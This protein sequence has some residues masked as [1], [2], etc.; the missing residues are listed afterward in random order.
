MP[1]RTSER[2]TRRAIEGLDAGR[3]IRDHE[4]PGLSCWRSQ[5]ARGWCL[6]Y[7][8]PRSGR[9]RR[10]HLGSYPDLGVGEAREAARAWRA[11]IAQGIDPRDEAGPP[12]RPLTIAEAFRRY[13][14]E[15]L[16]DHRRGQEAARAMQRDLIDE[17]GHLALAELHRRHVAEMH[18]RIRQ[19]GAPVM[20]NRLVSAASAFASW[21]VSA[22]LLDQSPLQG[23]RRQISTRE[24][25]RDRVLSDTELAALWRASLG[26][27]QYGAAFR[28]LALTGQRR[29]EVWLMRDSW[30]DGPWCEVPPEFY[31][32]A[33]PHRFYLTGLARAQLPAPRPDGRYFTGGQNWAHR[34]AVLAARAGIEDWTLHDLRRT[35]ATGLQRLGVLPD[36]IEVCLGHG[37]KG[38]MRVYQR[39]AYEDERRAAF[40]LWSDHVGGLTQAPG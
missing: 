32:V 27:G 5:V 13:R 37:A 7:R 38:V 36:L 10:L 22:G 9:R 39:H 20:A 12:P 4:V 3:E 30:L 1:R 40:Q 18:A 11:R 14:E 21:C 16:A 8:S 35:F 29:G 24:P 34:K 2:L 31:K 17:I 19:R 6:T 15:R 26:L 25:A 23:I 33:R 28:V